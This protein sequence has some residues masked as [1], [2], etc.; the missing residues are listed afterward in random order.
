MHFA[1]KHDGV[2]VLD[3][4]RCAPHRGGTPRVPASRPLLSVPMSSAKTR[5]AHEVAAVRDKTADAFVNGA[6]QQKLFARTFSRS[7]GTKSP[8]LSAQGRCIKRAPEEKALSPVSVRARPPAAGLDCQS[9]F[10]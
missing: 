5:T 6:T 9:T 7:S 8:A 10:A 3:I 1:S 4:L 2:P